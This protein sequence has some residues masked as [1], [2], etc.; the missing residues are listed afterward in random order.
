MKKYIGIF[1]FL[2]VD[3][4]VTGQNLVPNGDFESVRICPFDTTLKFSKD[5]YTPN[6]G[7]PDH[8]TFLVNGWGCIPYQGAVGC[9]SP[10]I[11]YQGYQLPHTGLGYG[12]FGT[13]GLYYDTTSGGEYLASR[14]SDSLQGNKKYCVSYWVNVANTSRWALDAIGIAFRRDSILGESSTVFCC[15]S[16]DVDSPIGIFI[17]DTVNWIL[18]QDTFIA[19]GGEKFMIIGHLRHN[20]LTNYLPMDTLGQYEGRAAYYYVDDVSVTY[21]DIP[22]DTPV[23]P[24]FPEITLTPNP[25]NGEFQIKGNF[26]PDTRIELFDLLGQKLSVIEVPEGSQS[27]TLYFNFGQAVYFYRV[28]SDGQ[29]LKSGKLIIVK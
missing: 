2:F 25:G 9:V 11:N 7:T 28:I 18:V 27:L 5:W 14:L 13:G 16:P 4:E 3:I 21:C 6:L 29:E 8:F 24:E 19:R 12:G 22:Q 20:N 23:N 15:S 26:P 1:L 10:N 17:S